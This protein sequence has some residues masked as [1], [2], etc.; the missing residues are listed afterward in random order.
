MSCLGLQNL[1]GILQRKDTIGSQV[2]YTCANLEHMN[3]QPEV[4]EMGR[5]QASRDTDEP[6]LTEIIHCD[7]VF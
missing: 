7:S 5:D 6:R 1:P 4:N 3:D 2:G